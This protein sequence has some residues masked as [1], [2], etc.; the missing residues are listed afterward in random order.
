MSRKFLV[1]VLSWWL[2]LA[3]IS[4]LSQK[5]EEED[6]FTCDDLV[7]LTYRVFIPTQQFVCFEFVSADT[8]IETYEDAGSFTKSYSIKGEGLGVCKILTEIPSPP[9]ALGASVRAENLIG[10]GFTGVRPTI[11]FPVLGQRVETGACQP[12]LSA[13][14]LKK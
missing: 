6:L 1:L 8:V 14:S 7:G 4:S 12:G 13:D 11:P 5:A 9:A 2:F 10:I 3:P